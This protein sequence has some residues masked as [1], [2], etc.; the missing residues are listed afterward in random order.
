MVDTQTIESLPNAKTGQ[1]ISLVETLVILGNACDKDGIAHGM[2]IST[3]SVPLPLR[4]AEVMGFVNI[5]GNNVELT[6]IGLE[7]NAA[8]DD[9]KRQLFGEKLKHL[10]PFA[11]IVRALEKGSLTKEDILNLIKA[12][13][14]K[15]RKWKPSSE[16]EMFRTIR[17]WC[18]YGW[19]LKEEE[20]GKY[21]VV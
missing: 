18:E 2:G 6:D 8:N 15:A 17:N 3:K 9:G 5:D 10:E 20:D 16:E 1:I 12:K 13:M 7:F 4:A 14:P 11:T 19:L 21:K